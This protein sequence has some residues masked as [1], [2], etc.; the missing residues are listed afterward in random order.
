M[1][2]NINQQY[3]SSLTGLRAIAAWNVFFVLSGFL[4]TYRYFNQPFFNFKKYMVNRFARIYPMYFIVSVG[5]FVTIYF[6]GEQWN[7]ETTII[8]LLNFTMS[9]ALFEKYIYT[10]VMQGWTLTL[11]ELFYLTAPFYFFLINKR[12]Y[13]LIILPILIF[14]FGSLLKYSFADVENFGGFMQ[15]NISTYVVEFF[16][17]IL[18]GLLILKKIA[19]PLKGYFTYFGLLLFDF[20]PLR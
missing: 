7:K 5:A 19:I 12:W 13:W 4:I 14:C 11:E 8:L 2:F 18:V 1:S 9:K 10:G 6:S 3:F 15:N 20:L 17:G 16:A